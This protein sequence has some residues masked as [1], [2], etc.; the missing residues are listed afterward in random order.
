MVT[1]ARDRGA[2]LASAIEAERQW[3]LG[4]TLSDWRTVLLVGL[5]AALVA[6]VTCQSGC[7]KPS[8]GANERSAV[9]MVSTM[10]A[11]PNTLDVGIKQGL[12]NSPDDPYQLYW[13]G[14]VVSCRLAQTMAGG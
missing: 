13:Q 8:Q 11:M 4:V 12:V 10:A 2:A 3:R 7:W 14:G 9:E 1:R 6:Y 5:V